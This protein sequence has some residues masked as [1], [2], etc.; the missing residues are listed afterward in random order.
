M[1]FYYNGQ[2]ASPLRRMVEAKRA[3]CVKISQIV[4][5]GRPMVAPTGMVEIEM[6]RLGED[7]SNRLST[8]RLERR[9]LRYDDN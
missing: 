7:F 5:C 3:V 1:Y 4:C 9:P 2:R 6:S 8:G